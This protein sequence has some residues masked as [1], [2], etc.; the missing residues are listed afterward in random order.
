MADPVLPPLEEAIALVPPPGSITW[1]R[2]GDARLMVGAGYALLLQVSHPTVGRGRQRALELQGGPVGP[3][4]AHAR[5]RVLDGLRRARAG[6]ADRRARAQD[7]QADQGRDKPDGRRY[8][9]LEPEAYAWVHATLA[10][11]IVAGHARFGR[12]MRPGRGRATST[13]SGAASAAC[14]ACATA[15]C[16]ETWAGFRAYFDEMV[17]DRLEFTDSVARR[18]RRRSTRRRG[19]P[20]VPVGERAWRAAR[21]PAARLS[22]LATI[23]PAAAGPARAL[24]AATGRRGQELELRALGR[25]VAR[26]HARDAGE[27]AQ[28]RPGA[29]WSAAARRSCAAACSPS[30][31]A[32]ARPSRGAEPAALSLARST[33]R[34]SRP[35]TRS[36]SACSTPRWPWPPP[37]ACG[38]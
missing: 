34:S 33:R 6:R 35:T 2:A 9:A 32:Q 1:R 27:P 25:G 14:S 12:P 11:A 28:D 15:T 3:A 36:A 24:R 38:T 18:A 13:T 20:L 5:L 17:A 23:G 8:H 21:F 7:A 22:A 16:R 29:G 10:D 26:R 30:R 31:D 19:R 37:R 4:A